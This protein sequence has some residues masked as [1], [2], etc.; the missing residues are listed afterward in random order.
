MAEEKGFT[1]TSNWV[2]DT[3]VCVVVV[4]FGAIAL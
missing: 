2:D 3:K 4:F 1:C